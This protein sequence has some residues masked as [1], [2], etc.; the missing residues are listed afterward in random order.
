MRKSLQYL[1]A[2]MAMG[3]NTMASPSSLILEARVSRAPTK[4]VKKI[5]PSADKLL[6]KYNAILDSERARIEKSYQDRISRVDSL[7]TAYLYRLRQKEQMEGDT[8]GF[9]EISKEISRVE[10]NHEPNEGDVSEEIQDLRNKYSS[11]MMR[12]E[13]DRRKQVVELSKKWN[14]KMEYIRS[15]LTRQ[16]RIEDAII[17][18]A[19]ISASKTNS[20]YSSSVNL[21]EKVLILEPL[22]NPKSEDKIG[23]NE[24]QES[25]DVLRM[26]Y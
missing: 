4:E 22:D 19:A 12:L 11:S 6:G 3:V 13:D 2:A 23:T 8:M 25:D 20:K 24:D 15:E 14:R 9:I 18:D 10:S 7:Y 21:T 26:E 17:I 16:Y 5:L 1:V